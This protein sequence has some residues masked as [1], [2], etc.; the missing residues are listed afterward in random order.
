MSFGIGFDDTDVVNPALRIVRDNGISYPNFATKPPE[1]A[2][3][4]RER[5]GVLARMRS[6]KRY[7]IFAVVS[8]GWISPTPHPSYATLS[9]RN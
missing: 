7:P 9:F 1:H 4:V 2:D 3:N 5:A 8:V 6:R